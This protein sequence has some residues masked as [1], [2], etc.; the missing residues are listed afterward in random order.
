MSKITDKIIPR[1][2]VVI[3]L[4]VLAGVAIIFKMSYTMFVD[5]ERWVE[6]AKSTVRD[7]VIQKATRGRILSSEG[8]LMA[9]SLPEYKIILDF[10]AGGEKQDS[11]LALKLDSMCEGLARIIPQ[12]TAAEF[13]ARILEGQ[14]QR[15][16][17]WPIYN[18]RISFTQFKDI[19]ELPYFNIKN[20]NVSGFTWEEFGNRRKKPFGSLAS[21]TLGSVKPSNDSAVSGLEQ[22]YDSILR[23][24]DGF[25]HR[26]K[27]RNRWL[28]ITDVPP[29]NGSDLV[30]TIDVSMQ[31]ICEKALKDKMEEINANVGVVVLMEVATGDV[32][33]IVNLGKQDDGTF[34]EDVPHAISDMME[35]GS[36]FKTASMMVILENNIKKLSD[37]VETGNGIKMMH[38]SP[39][40]DH[41]WHRGGYGTITVPQV[42][43]Y[44]SNVGTS[45]IIDNYYF[46][47]PQDYVQCLYNIGI[48]EDLKLPFK[49]YKKP[50]IRMPEKDKTGKHWK[51][52]SNTS[53]AW[54]S[55]GYETQ[56]APINTVTF[57]N[58]IANNGK[59]MRPRFVKHIEKDG[60][61]IQEFKPEVIKEQICKPSTI[62][63]LKQILRLVVKD[64]VAKQ[65]GTKQFM[66]AGKTGTAQ[67]SQG[68]G[69]YKSGTT[70]YLISF[71]GFFP[72]DDPKYT[73]IVCMQKKGSPA[74]G[75]TMCGPVFRSIAEK[76][77][78]K[79]LKRTLLEA[80]D[81]IHMHVPEVKNG[82][83]LATSY[84]LNQLEIEN[85]QKSQKAYTRGVTVWGTGSSE[86]H[87][88]TLTKHEI[89]KKVVPNVLG[90]GARDALYLLENCGLKVKI[91]GT[92]KVVGQNIYAG[93]KIE[94]GATITL[95]LKQ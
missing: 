73:C 94:K 49:E 29:V 21:R 33:A 12:K 37:K 48:A 16:R 65:A 47:H 36:T 25:V 81:T 85:N 61:I 42:L 17:Y 24:T 87:Q 93:S 74:S 55:I 92:G 2:M 75:G 10:K 72:Y 53:L 63:K 76:V 46:D 52:W 83:I 70:C 14:K 68:K 15:K 7:S 59:M 35:P 34:F 50:R 80:N 26:Q 5:R 18:R 30:T 79:D 31:D 32:K 95:T 66:V 71:C 28:S 9:S 78:A 19:Q 3:A 64:G 4:I 57:Y 77:Y 11:L 27:V 82:N 90:M 56:I 54:M 40:K 6:I 13:K 69:G 38:G 39:M 88:V 60:E 58:A 23:G 1:Y 20:R 8:Q 22:T 44:S 86:P 84:V 91:E 43:M 51:N 62:N 45:T 41:N 89:S 67:I